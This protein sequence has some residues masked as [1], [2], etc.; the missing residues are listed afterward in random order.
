[1]RIAHPLLLLPLPANEPLDT[2]THVSPEC[3]SRRGSLSPY[4]GEILPAL[5]LFF[6]PRPKF[7]TQYRIVAPWITH[8]RPRHEILPVEIFNFRGCSGVERGDNAHRGRVE[9]QAGKKLIDSTF[10]R[11]WEMRDDK[12]ETITHCWGRECSLIAR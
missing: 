12:A 9:D 6:E 5:Y 3:L 7:L 1:M 8:L 11:N 4:C 10:S 2:S